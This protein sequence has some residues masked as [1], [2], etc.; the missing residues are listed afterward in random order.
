MK[1][2]KDYTNRCRNIPCLWIGIINIVKM[3]IQPKSIYRFD[4]IPIK[5]PTVFLRE[6]EEIILQFVWKYKNLES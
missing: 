3:I 2:I 4:T 1:E 6:L 5:L